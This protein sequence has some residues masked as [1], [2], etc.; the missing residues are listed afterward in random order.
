MNWI[1][2]VTFE[3]AEKIVNIVLLKRNTSLGIIAPNGFGKT[4]M[5]K[6]LYNRIPHDKVRVY[7][8]ADMGG[9]RRI[10]R[11]KQYENVEL[12]IIPDMQEIFQ[13]KYEVINS[14]FGELRS[15]S[16]T[17]S[18]DE[19]EANFQRLSENEDEKDVKSINHSYFTIIAGTPNHWNKLC[20]PNLRDFST[21]LPVLELIQRTEKYRTNEPYHIHSNL[22]SPNTI[23]SPIPNIKE[24]L[25][26]LED[27][28]SVPQNMERYRILTARIYEGLREY[29]YSEVESYYLVSKITLF[30]PDTF[31]GTYES[32]KSKRITTTSIEE[33]YIPTDE[34]FVPLEKRKP[35][36]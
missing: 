35:E 36:S 21:A 23:P 7:R 16:E 1:G 3:E 24:E 19:V 10:G 5:V 29:G 27:N 11:M 17:F 26:R 2:K 30:N 25:K 28:L 32:K 13:R 4:E 18:Q 20:Y 6:C 14:T 22:P 34:S 8:R 33:E 12:I 9:L 15:V 31:R